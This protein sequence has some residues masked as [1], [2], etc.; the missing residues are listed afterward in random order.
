MQ[1]KDRFYT[2]FAGLR[3]ATTPGFEARTLVPYDRLF[4]AKGTHPESKHL[5]ALVAGVDPA[6]KTVTYTPIDAATGQPVT[7][8]TASLTYDYLVLA[9]GA[10]YSEPIKL[11]NYGIAQARP[12]IIEVQNAVQASNSIVVVGGGV[13]G[14]E[15]AGELCAVGKK[16]TLVHSGE[17]LLDTKAGGPPFPQKFMERTRARLEGLGAKVI[18]KSRAERPSGDDVTWIG[19]G[20]AKSATAGASFN[21]KLSTGA[22]VATDLAFFVTGATPNTS[23][24]KSGAL[25]STLDET[26]RVKVELTYQVKGHRNI[27]AIG[28][29]CASPD[30]KSAWLIAGQA[31]IVSENVARLAKAATA[32]HNKEPTLKKGKATGVGGIALIPFGT[33]HG[34]GLLPFGMVGDKF[35]SGIKG[36]DV[37]TAMAAGGLGYTNINEVV[38]INN[39]A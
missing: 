24:L 4:K 31:G 20:V 22:S 14:V 30:A 7:S 11:S 38:A 26:G 35:T 10:N 33:K 12:R 17:R 3:V 32:N 5:R 1:P 28:D 13:T 39:K 8:A 23:F 2:N 19:S 29:C 25:A 9:T 34:V 21:L 18:L 6:T 27:F 36:K 16:V 15:L 37:F